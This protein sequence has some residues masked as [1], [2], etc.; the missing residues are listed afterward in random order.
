MKRI[1]TLGLVLALTGLGSSVHAAVGKTTYPVVFAHGLAGWDNILG[2]FYFG[3]GTGNFVGD[4]CDA[5]LELDCNGNLNA[6]QKARH[7]F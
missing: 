3:D 7:L 6:G 1:L 2:A 4:P 5:F